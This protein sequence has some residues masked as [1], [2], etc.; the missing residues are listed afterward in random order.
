MESNKYW[1]W[2][3]KP[4]LRVTALPPASLHDLGQITSSPKP[5]FS[6]CD[7]GAILPALPSLGG[8]VKLR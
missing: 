8:S 6:C 5:Q 7:M 4:W 1:I 3:P 2:S